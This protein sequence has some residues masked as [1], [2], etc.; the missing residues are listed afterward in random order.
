MNIRSGVS[1]KESTML[2]TIPLEVR[3]SL[4]IDSHQHRVAIGLAS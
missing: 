2:E 3:V 4:D 1:V